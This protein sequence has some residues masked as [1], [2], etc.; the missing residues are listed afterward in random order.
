MFFSGI[1]RFRYPSTMHL[2]SGS[3]ASVQYYIFSHETAACYFTG[4][5]VQH[6]AT[7]CQKTTEYLFNHYLVFGLKFNLSE[8]QKT[9]L[10]PT[11]SGK[12]LLAFIQ[13]YFVETNHAIT[14]FKG[15]GYQK[16]LRL[17][18]MILMCK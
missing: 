3:S 17:L 7:A 9:V 18:R 2:K 8:C 11:N 1:S 4:M 13:A 16:C 10:L 12:Q 14:G 6:Q 15:Y 5:N